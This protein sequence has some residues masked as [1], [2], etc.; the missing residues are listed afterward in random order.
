M[1]IYRNT[2]LSTTDVLPV[3]L[4]VHRAVH[5]KSPPRELLATSS[6]RVC[7]LILTSF[8]TYNDAWTSKS[9]SFFLPHCFVMTHCFF[10]STLLADM[11]HNFTVCT[12]QKHRHQGHRQSSGTCSCSLKSPFHCDK[13]SQ[14][15]GCPSSTY[16]L[17]SM[18]FKTNIYIHI[19]SRR[20]QIIVVRE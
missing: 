16:W 9:P 20:W 12:Q 8:C 3:Y 6:T 11:A 7:P 13:K 19:L 5:S 18:S 17:Y 2:V 1:R 4:S 14:W 10:Y 15:E